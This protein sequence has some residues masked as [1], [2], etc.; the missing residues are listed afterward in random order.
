VLR[1]TISGNTARAQVLGTGTAQAKTQGGGLLNI[2]TLSLELSTVAGNVLSTSGG[3]TTQQNGG[4]LDLEGTTESLV[5]STIADNGPSAVSGTQTANG[6]NVRFAT[7]S[8]T[9][10]SSIIASPAGD[11][12]NANCSA[13]ATSSDGFSDEFASANPSCFSPTEGTFDPM[14]GPLQ[15]NGGPT[16]TMLP[17]A[18][19]P[20][21]D[22]GSAADQSDPSHDQRGSARPADF[23]GIANP[24]GGDGSDIG[25]VEV[26]KDCADQ[27]TP[28][29]TCLSTPPPGGGSTPPPSSS[30]VKKKKK[31]KKAKKRSASS[32]KKKKCKKKKKR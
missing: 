27:A 28:G 5:S 19:S 26:Q 3:T 6:A 29:G 24:L 10:S 25:A 32:A 20:V 14:L 23:S 21:I 11:A 16:S 31:C 8:W 30:P 9:V 1:S 2:G 12:M 13:A 17:A 15:P 18:N 4:G 7:G 22:Q